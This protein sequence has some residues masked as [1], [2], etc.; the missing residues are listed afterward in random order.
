MLRLAYGRALALALRYSHVTLAIGAGTFALAMLI[1]PKLGTEFL[2]HLDEGN[3]YIRASL[4]QTISYTESAHFVP[5]VRKIIAGFQ[6]VE[7]VQSQIGR[8]DDATD[9]STFNNAEF[10]VDLKP[11]DQW[12]GFK[13]KEALIDAMSERFSKIPGVTFNFSQNIEDNVE[14]AV[15]GVKGELAVKLYGEDLDM[16]EK[17]ANEIQDVMAKIPGVVDLSVFSE[18]GEPQVRVIVDRDRCA[19]YGLNVSD[20]QD[21][22]QTQIGGQQFTTFLDGEKQFA[23]SVRLHANQRNDVGHIQDVAIDTP[24]GTRVP[25]SMVADVRISRGAA[26]VYREAGQRFIAIK[27]GVRGRDIGGTVN[28]AQ[29]LVHDKVQLPAG[30]RVAF[31]GEFESM[32]RASARLAIILPLTIAMIFLVLFLLFGNASRS[33]IVIMNVPLSLSGAIFALY[34]TGFHLSVSAAVGFIALFGVAV[35]NGVIMVS[36]IDH[37]CLRDELLYDAVLDGASVRLRPVLM[38]AMLATI[39]LIPAAI[40]TSIGSDVQKPLAIAIIGGLVM[41][42]VIGTLFVLPVLYMLVARRYP[43]KVMGDEEVEEEVQ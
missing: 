2:P 30:Y 16:L 43:A 29:K 9:A 1:L 27:F 42:V 37:L 34:L 20:V 33:A 38:T 24:D 8:P 4:P 13:T 19:R 15:T 26:F 35:Q 10:L 32:Q 7:L 36:Y 22:V 28:D 23:V 14:E 41:D 3:L 40:S 39:G 25:L 6:P 11:Y 18:T 21:A 5:A 12:K 17:K 31:G